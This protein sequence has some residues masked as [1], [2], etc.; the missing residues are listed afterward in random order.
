MKIYCH[1]TVWNKRAHIPWICEGIRKC[2][3]KGSII[4][5]VFDNCTDGS[6][7][8]FKSLV[9]APPNQYG[10]LH[11][12]SVRSFDSEK[13]LRMPN[14]NDAIERFMKSDCALFLTPQDDMKIQDKRIV[15][16]LIKLYQ[17]VQNIG[18]VGM[19]DGIMNNEFYSANHSPGGGPTNQTTFLIS[20]EYKAVS[21]VNDGPLCLSKHT[22][23]KVGLFDT[24]FWAHYIDN[25]YC[26]RAEAQALQNYVMGAEIVHEKWGQIQQS[27]VWNQEYSTHD[28]ELYKTKWP[29]KL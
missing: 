25:D 23:E 4:D 27:E 8:E 12:F 26:W 10:S 18:L 5:F 16:N 13:K 22:I 20:G 21:F 9:Y 2:I 19:R 28:W 15:P 11:G 29:T 17:E 7:D 6:Q 14:T 3:P 24:E 1:Y